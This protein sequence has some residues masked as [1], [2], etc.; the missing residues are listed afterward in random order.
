MGLYTYEDFEKKA[1]E[2]GLSG[3]IS[4]ADLKLAKNNPDAGV[5]ILNAKNDWNNATTD[6]GRALANARA[7]EA[8]KAFGGY[9]GGSSGSQFTSYTPSSFSSDEGTKAQQKLNEYM[10]YKP[11]S[12]N[13]DT[14]DVYSSYA[15]AYTREG[16]RASED[17]LAQ[18]AA[19]TG[20]IPSSYAVTAGQ[21]AGNY[22]ASQLADKIPE[23][24][25][26]A[27]NR[28]QS[29]KNDLLDAYQLLMSADKEKYNRHLDDIA[30]RQS[31]RKYND[32]AELGLAVGDY[33]PFEK[34]EL[35]P[36]LEKI[37]NESSLFD[38]LREK[39]DGYILPGY[40][41]DSKDYKTRRALLSAG[42]SR[43][44]DSTTLAKLKYAYSDG[45]I[46]H[47]E[48]VIILSEGIMPDDLEEAG[49][50]EIEP[51]KE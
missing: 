51:G 9:T 4:E 50:Y 42:F 31:E 36:D 43:Q 41:W 8:R 11:F 46:P 16:R 28:Y 15:K 20:G 22:Y 2:Y 13:P 21:Q 30:Y 7:E 27:Y 29:E 19:M 24:E 23:L 6:E 47:D 39:Y 40:E 17:T 25:D 33:S 18:A 1:Q 49:F 14:D 34:L 35:T 26:R 10:N 45:A 37:N 3:Q 12:Y 32:D 38:S 48:W 44:L 5:Q